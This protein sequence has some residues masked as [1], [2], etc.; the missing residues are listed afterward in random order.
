MRVDK[1]GIISRIHAKFGDLWWYTVLLF[2]AQRFCDVINMFVGLWIVPRYVPMEELGAVL[3]ITA[4]V[5]VMALPLSMISTP[6]LKYLTLFHDLGEEGKVKAL[7]RHVFLGTILLSFVTMALSLFILPFFFERMRVP[8]GS[9]AVL[10]VA[11][12]ILGSVSVIFGDAVRGLKLYGTTVG[13]Q[14][15][16]AP[17][18]LLLMLVFM[19]FRPLSGYVIGQGAAPGIGVLG[20]FWKLR[21][22]LWGR[23]TI[24]SESYWSEY[25]HAILRYAWPFAVWTLV[26]TISGSID[27]LIIRQ[28][29]SEFESAGYYMITRF[30]DMATYMASAFAMFLF[31]MVASRGAEDEES[32]K[33]LVNSLLGSLGCGMVITL[34]LWIFGER[35]LG[36]HGSWRSYQ[37][38]SGQMVMTSFISAVGGTVNCLFLYEIAQGRFRFMWYAVPIML[39]KSF[40][41]YLLVGISFF[42]GILPND[43]ITFVEDFN[44]CRLS[45]MLQVMLTAQVLLLVALC[46]DVFGIIS[47]R[48]NER[49]LEIGAD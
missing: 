35:L 32:R 8:A 39:V 1:V 20:A 34:F 10:M 29:L 2:F 7:L 13:L 24:A 6:F 44:P 31:P 19:P 49:N 9:L 12:A 47:R 4:F 17:F 18:R 43:W 27:S 46:I 11:V 26:G 3:P 16:A 40:G 5:G 23:G 25:G 21:G 36:L 41:L 45:F 42:S 15:L 38:L 30:S 22:Y 33:T 48:K 14:F 28:R 37:T